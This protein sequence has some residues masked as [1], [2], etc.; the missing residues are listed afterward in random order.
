[1]GYPF[2]PLKVFLIDNWRHKGGK[3]EWQWRP[4]EMEGWMAGGPD[5]I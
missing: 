2:S 1:M 5:S 4:T 3:E